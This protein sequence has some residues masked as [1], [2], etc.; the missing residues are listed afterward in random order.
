MLCSF[1]SPVVWLNRRFNTRFVD[2]SFFYIIMFLTMI[3][4]TWVREWLSLFIIQFLFIFHSRVYGI[5]MELQCCVTFH[6][7]FR[8]LRKYTIFLFLTYSL[9]ILL[10]MLSLQCLNLFLKSFSQFNGNKFI[11][12]VVISK[13]LL[14]K[15]CLHIRYREK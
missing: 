7:H 13:Y 14:L 3:F 12:I 15:V 8:A 11:E 1:T 9:E 4:M 2:F 10:F 6:P 5:C